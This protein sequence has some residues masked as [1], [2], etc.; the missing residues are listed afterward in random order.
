MTTK[1]QICD[2]MLQHII[3]GMATKGS[4]K[5]RRTTPDTAEKAKPEKPE[6]TP[7]RKIAIVSTRVLNSLIIQHEILTTATHRHVSRIASD[8]TTDAAFGSV[9]Y[10][11]IAMRHAHHRF[12]I[13]F[14]RI[15]LS[16]RSE[17]FCNT[18]WSEA[19]S[20]GKLLGRPLLAPEPT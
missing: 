6:T 10:L 13:P 2:A 15:A 19:D 14:S 4:R 1:E 3:R 7:P 20:K 5:C 16:Q 12:K 18:F 8:G 17:E 9:R 11:T